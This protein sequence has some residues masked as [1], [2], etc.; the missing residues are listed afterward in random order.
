[1]KVLSAIVLVSLFHSSVDAFIASPTA[2]VV[3]CHRQQQQQQQLRPRNTLTHK[4]GT[5][6]QEEEVET[7]TRKEGQHDVGLYKKFADHAYDRL[8]SS[9]YF[10]ESSSVPNHL[11]QNEAPAKGMESSIVKISTKAFV[12]SNIGRAQNLVRYARITLLETV[13][14]T[15]AVSEVDDTG[16]NIRRRHSSGIHVLNF[17]ILPSDQTNLPALGIDLVSLPGSK[18]LLLMD[19][20]PMVQPNPHEDYM[21]QWYQSYAVSPNFP[22]GGD[23]PEQVKQYVSKNA[24]WTRL[25]D[26]TENPIKVIEEHVWD[27]FVEHLDLYLNLFERYQHDVESIQGPNVQPAY[28]DYRRTNDPAKPMLNSLYGSE[29]TESLLDEVLFPKE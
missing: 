20:Q 10:T 13:P 3:P 17:V 19:S 7:T 25:Q 11:Q 2:V 23:F 12:P 18:H 16:S 21:T 4:R 1:M 8:S 5:S 14:V 26:I 29:W 27:A 24:L 9:M 28:L 6:Q 15:A 22:W